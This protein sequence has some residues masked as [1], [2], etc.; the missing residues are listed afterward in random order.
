MA[1]ARRS[2]EPT[3]A[4]Q[5]IGGVAATC[6]AVPVG[7]GAETYCATDH[8]AVARWDTAAVNV[9]LQAMEPTADPAAFA[10]PGR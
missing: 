9:E 10:L 6:A 8:G 2:G 3:A 7:S 1:Y 4:T 5:A